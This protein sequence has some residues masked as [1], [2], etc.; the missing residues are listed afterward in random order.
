M[1]NEY[2]EA[3]SNHQIVGGDKCPLLPLRTATLL[4][5]PCHSK[6]TFAF[7]FLVVLLLAQSVVEAQDKLYVGYSSYRAV[8]LTINIILPTTFQH[9][10]WY[11]WSLD[12]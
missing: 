2:K 8:I 1:N 12:G 4:T 11:I 10:Y 7:E 5:C 3:A 9:I 6:K